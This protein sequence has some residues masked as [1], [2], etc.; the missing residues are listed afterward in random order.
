[1]RRNRVYLLALTALLVSGCGRQTKVDAKADPPKVEVEEAPDVNVI[2]VENP[3]QFP[4]VVVE[5][6][7]VRDEVKTSA[8]VAPDVNRTVPVVSMT[9]GRVVEIRAKLGDEVRKGDVLLLINS[10]DISQVFSDYQKF[11]ASEVLTQKQLERSQLLYSKGALA[12]KDLQIAE[13]T[14]QKAKVDV[15]TAAERIRILGADLNH[16]SPLIEVRA[17]V[18]GTIVEQNV[19]GAAG[20]KSLDNSPNLFTIADLSRVWVLCD[21]Y[22]NNLRQVRVGDYADVQLNAYPDRTFKGRVSNISRIL[23][24]A[25]RSAKVR[26]ELENPGGVMRAGMFAT[27][28]F[29]SQT[30]QQR[31]AAPASAVLRLHD[32]DWVFRFEGEKRLRRTEVQAGAVSSDGFQEILRGVKPGERVVANALQF[33]SATEHQ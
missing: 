31:A 29:H 5:K 1:M 33:A 22:E 9:A 18:S 4:L 30:G 8:A 26:L 2:E 12:Q 16:P 6:R 24:P 23:D 28:T 19:A 3:R 11:Q 10:P 21:V 13:D 27:A 14:A 17:P 7:R 20:V 32:K 15:A 25:T